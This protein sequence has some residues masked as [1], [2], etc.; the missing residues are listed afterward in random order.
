MKDLSDQE[1][2]GR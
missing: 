2:I 1:C